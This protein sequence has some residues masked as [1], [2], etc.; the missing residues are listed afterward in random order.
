MKK[1]MMTALAAAMAS[2][3]A[4]AEV[5]VPNTFTQ[6]ENAVAAEV[7]ANFGALVT[8]I[9][10]S[11]SR[12]AAL[13]EQLDS[14][15]SLEVVGSSYTIQ[16]SRVTLQRIDDDGSNS[17]AEVATHG[18]EIDLSTEQFSLTFNEDAE[19][20]AT[21]EFESEF[22]GDIDFSGRLELEQDVAPETETLYWSQEG[23]VLQVSES[24]NGSPVVTFVV[25]EGAAIIYAVDKESVVNENTGFSCG[26]N[27]C[28]EDYFTSDT[29][30]GIRQPAPLP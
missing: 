17:S 10:E 22:Q 30:L 27:P 7:N 23:N 11:N 24:F 4:V 26:A 16:T 28:F 9:E 20:T 21:L 14:A 13:E 2:S 1:F 12:I 29:L 3:V 25:A 19:K 15:T 8:A 18:A 5:S 6:G